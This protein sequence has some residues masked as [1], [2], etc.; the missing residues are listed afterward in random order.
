MLDRFTDLSWRN[1]K[2]VAFVLGMVS[3][4]G[5]PPVHLIFMIIPALSGIVLLLQTV[6]TPR[7]AFTLG[8]FFGFGYF[9]AGL[10][11]VSFA[12]QAAGVA[13][14]MPLAIFGLP[15]L[16]AIFPALAIVSTYLLS[17]KDIV[18]R[19]FVFTICLS[20]SEWLRGH[21][22]TGFPWNL[23]GYVWDL[24]ML[25]TTAWV[26]IYGLTLLTILA[27][28]IVATRSTRWVG[29][30]WAVML[31][32]WIGGHYRLEGS[33][34][35]A[36][37]TVNMR[38]VQ[39]SIPQQQKHSLEHLE[40]NLQKHI[41]LSQL[42]AEKPLQAVLWAESTVPFF[43]DQ[44]PIL[45]KML[46]EAVPLD[47]GFLLF[48]NP[49]QSQ[50]GGVTKYWNSLLA[51]NGE[52]KILASYDKT[53]L[54][55]FGEYIPFRSIFSKVPKLTQGT[56]DFTQGH[57]FETINLSDL[58]PFSPLVCYEAIFPGAVTDHDDRPDWILNITNDAWYGRTSGPYQHL[59][60]VRVRAIEE[61]LPLVRVAN[62]G[63]SAV[64][65]PYG[66]ILYQLGLDEIG[67][68]DFALPK[69]IAPSF[70][71][72][73]RNSS[74]WLMIIGLSLITCYLRR[75]DFRASNSRALHLHS[76]L[77]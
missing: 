61:G 46:S 69:A 42:P 5:L 63:I 36:L 23:F 18:S 14:L 64:I 66:R 47:G 33:K 58:P 37:T 35:V 74:F 20:M 39:A 11:W 27:A 25:Q 71:T 68:V 24:S 28:S 43:V 12:L 53:H 19:V 40:K 2:I 52:G 62:N 50:E 4:L 72:H 55:P 51:L 65:D 48:G 57:G 29:S 26:G 15:A 73:W 75:A 56:M 21:I 13:Y 67:F 34:D 30:V 1:R 70:Y 77:L 49:R 16:L 32:L 76:M 6:S 3:V 44:Y 45:R 60:I 31:V 54:V 8:Y 9:F 38:I 17:S 59:A 10:Y 7:Q 41:A 22:F